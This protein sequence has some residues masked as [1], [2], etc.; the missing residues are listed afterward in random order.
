[1]EE[2]KTLNYSGKLF[3]AN[4]QNYRVGSLASNNY[5]NAP[6]KYFTLDKNEIKAYTKYGKPFEKTWNARDL[7]L[8]NILDLSTRQRLESL[9]NQN[10]KR[11]LRIAFPIVNGE[12]SRISEEN[13]K[14][15]DDTVLK[16]LCELGFDGYLMEK[17]PNRF[18]SEVGLCPTAFSKLTLLDSKRALV[19][20]SL[21]SRTKR[22]SRFNNNNN[23]NKNNNNN[24]R[25]K[26]SFTNKNNKNK[27]KPLPKFSLF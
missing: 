3:R 12:V 10:Q 7:N 4:T 25:K 11:S 26:R 19:A 17:I 1:M 20:P 5:R 21:P 2:I 27:N 22:R 16:A 15:D 14:T 6:I 18:H 13:S 23:K 9:F 24:Y 8:V